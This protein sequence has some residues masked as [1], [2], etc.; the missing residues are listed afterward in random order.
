[1]IETIKIHNYKSIKDLDLK[2]Q[3][4]TILIGANGAGKSNFISFFKL[5]RQIKL[6]QL[7]TFVA[8]QGFMN[9]LMYLGKRVSNSI[10][11]EI[12]FLNKENVPTNK[13]IFEILADSRNKAFIK[14]EA[15]GYN[16]L[17]AVVDVPPKWD[18]YW[19][20]INDEYSYILGRSQILRDKYLRNYF[21]DFIIY[22]FHD[23]SFDAPLKQ[24]HKVDDNEY[25]KENGENLAAFLFYLQEKAPKVLK[26]IERVVASIAPFFEKFNLKPDRRN[27]QFIQ[28]EWKEKEFETYQNAHNLSDGTLRFI[29]LT[30]LLLQPNPPKTIII[31]EPELGLHPFAINKLAG[32]IRKV[33]AKSQV[34]LSTQSIDLVN[35]FEPKQIVT[36]DKRR[37][38]SV[39]NS[40]NAENLAVWLNDYSI[41][42][43]WYKSVI[44][45]QP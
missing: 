7:N 6:N 27:E 13:Y 44:G 42:D 17:A 14:S 40:L 38:E 28:L 39:F 31:D 10:K 26:R 15:S 19:H 5:L 30:T 4:I 43:L 20:N 2:L 34:I 36:V 32:L 3:P 24:F 16:E 33:S 35:N 45:G 23:T 21:N 1:M 18:N 11:G 41:G 9:N 12:S 29:A 25:L 37:G 22:H 8:S